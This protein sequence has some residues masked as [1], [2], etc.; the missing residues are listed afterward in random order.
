MVP[1]DFE[2][3]APV[4]RRTCLVGAA[5]LVGVV[6][7]LRSSMAIGRKSISVLIASRDNAVVATA[8]GQVRGYTRNGVYTFK[9]IPYSESTAGAN[10]FMPPV[11]LKPWS[12][13]RSC[14]AYGPVS[15]Q[16]PRPRLD[17]QN[18]E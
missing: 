2:T 18:D 4:S 7:A 14:M 13:V 17:W 3:G 15:P 11:K 10:R 12:G 9:G 1:F 6:T 8:G 5:T 16:P